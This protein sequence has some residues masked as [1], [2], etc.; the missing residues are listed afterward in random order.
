VI[1]RDD[2]LDRRWADAV[3]H[4]QSLGPGD[5]QQV[6]V[7]GRCVVDA[8]G[9]ELHRPGVKPHGVESAEEGGRLAHPPK[10][11]EDGEVPGVRILLVV[12]PCRAAQIE[13]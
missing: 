5:G 2:G 8:I 10:V 4:A 1:R 9:D 12:A 13:K 3:D 11:I 6:R 7:D